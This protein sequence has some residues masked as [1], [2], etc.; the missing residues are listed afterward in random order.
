MGPL[1]FERRSE[2][3]QSPRMPRL[4]YGPPMELVKILYVPSLL[5]ARFLDFEPFE[6]FHIAGEGFQLNI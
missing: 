1:R 5:Q 2:D 3:P 4:P 6:G